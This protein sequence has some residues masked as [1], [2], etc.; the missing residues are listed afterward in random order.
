M[1]APSHS[2]STREA[3]WAKLDRAPGSGLREPQQRDRQG[4][5]QRSRRRQPGAAWE[6]AADHQAG[7]GNVVARRAQ[8]GDDTVDEPLPTVGRRRVGDREA[9]AL[10]EVA[11]LGVDRVPVGER[12]GHRDADADRKRQR[13]PAVVV[14]VLA[15]QV[16]AP[17]G[18][19]D[20]QLAAVARA[21]GRLAAEGSQRRRPHTRVVA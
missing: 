19:G 4:D 5:R 2:C 14:G 20:D 7:G 21:I 13:Q 8:L 9:V 11:R 3:S 6:L 17:G 16:D 15:D 12:G 18:E 10:A 1:S